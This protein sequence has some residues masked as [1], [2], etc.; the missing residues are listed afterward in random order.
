MFHESVPGQIVDES[1]D[2]A[3]VVDEGT[4]K[5]KP[6]DVGV[7]ERELTVGEDSVGVGLTTHQVIC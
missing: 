6:I 1:V 4:V 2:F 5:V 3:G 7:L